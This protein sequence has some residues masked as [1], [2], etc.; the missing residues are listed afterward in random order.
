MRGWT[1]CVLGTAAL[2]GCGDIL[3]LD[4]YDLDGGGGVIDATTDTGDAQPDVKAD[5]T[6]GG[7]SDVVSDVVNDVVP[8]SPFTCNTTT[9]MCVPDLP[10]GWA[11]AVY[12]PDAR[13]ACASGWA[14]PADVDEGIDAGAAVCACGCTTTQPNCATGNLAITSGTNGTCDNIT[15]QTGTATAGCNGLNAFGTSGASFSVTPPAPSGGSCSPAPSTTLPTVG[16]AHVG[17][18]CALSA[19][20]G[21]GCDAGS[22]CVPNPAP[23]GMC[24]S[25]AGANTCPAGFTNQ[26]TIGSALADTRGCT[27]C[28]C[29]FDAG[30]C[31]GTASFY[32]NGGCTAGTST[33]NADGTC[34]AIGG[35]H[36]WRAYSYSPTTNG[37]CAGTSVSADGGVAFSDL[38]TVCCQ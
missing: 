33:I 10:S 24:I 21:G 23:F 6:D 3:G 37:S 29:T 12:D 28:G 7:G 36:T 9:S 4:Q 27:A 38:T 5:V 15:T 20:P 32:T 30:V 25:K 16:Y 35:N 34:H 19:A 22:V 11:W 26:H 13:P 2:A 8:D 17:R 18:T 1:I 31:S 14:A